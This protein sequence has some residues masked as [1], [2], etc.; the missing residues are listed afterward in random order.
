MTPARARPCQSLRV[1]VL[2]LN[3]SLSPLF[4]AASMIWPATRRT[5]V[6]IMRSRKCLLAL[7]SIARRYAMP[8]SQHVL[9]V[10]RKRR[11][12]VDVVLDL[13]GGDAK[14]HRQSEN[15]DQLLAGVSDE[16]RAENAIGR[17][18][19]D[20]FRPRHRLRISPG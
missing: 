4:A 17:P 16:M 3:M 2:R 6:E 7:E 20:N 1:F 10:G 14:A 18:V 13:A 5:I 8:A 9:D 15:V 11:V 19:D 12:G